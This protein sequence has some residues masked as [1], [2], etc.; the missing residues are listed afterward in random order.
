MPHVHKRKESLKER[1]RVLE[2]QELGQE[3]DSGFSN[4]SGTTGT[5]ESYE[6]D[7]EFVGGGADD[8]RTG[9]TSMAVLKVWICI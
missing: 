8:P 5:S 9:S 2:A 3:A 6:A 4:A 1:L 7:S